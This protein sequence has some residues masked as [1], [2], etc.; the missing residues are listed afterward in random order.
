MLLIIILWYQ[1]RYYSYRINQIFFY[2]K[3]CSS[4]KILLIKRSYPNFDFFTGV[5]CNLYWGNT[6]ITYGTYVV[7]E[8]V[9]CTKNFKKTAIYWNIVKPYISDM[10][11]C[12]LTITINVICDWICQK[13]S[14]SHRHSF[15][16]HFSLPLDKYNNRLTVHTYTFAKAS[17][18]C[19]Y[20]GL[21]HGA[22]W[23]P[24]MLGW[25]VNG[26][27]LPGQADSQ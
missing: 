21:I 8:Y 20:W 7:I 25:S 4:S 22:V 19:F 26:S 9:N 27:N 3:R 14:C 11:F 16:S 18:V 1:C 17:M 15:K 10:Q 5:S 2:L 13:V 23:H 12:N 6:Q 24:L